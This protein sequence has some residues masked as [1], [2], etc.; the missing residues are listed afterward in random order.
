MVSE[1][2]MQVSW[3]SLGNILR[4]VPLTA[5]FSM[6]IYCPFLWRNIIKYPL[7]LTSA[8]LRWVSWDK[9][10][11]YFVHQINEELFGNNSFHCFHNIMYFLTDLPYF[12]DYVEC[13]DTGQQDYLFF[14]IESMLAVNLLYGAIVKHNTGLL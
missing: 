5:N 12:T 8:T 13:V 9:V 7:K 6:Q 11:L 10:Q 4:N 2:S 14:T 3:P 1:F